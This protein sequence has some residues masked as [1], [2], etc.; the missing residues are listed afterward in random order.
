MNTENIASNLS[1]RI[2][3]YHLP[4]NLKTS[5][6]GELHALNMTIYYGGTGFY[7][8]RIIGVVVQGGG[9]ATTI[10]DCTPTHNHG[11]NEV[12]RSRQNFEA[13]QAVKGQGR[14]R[15]L[16]RNGQRRSMDMVNAGCMVKGQ[17]KIFGAV[18][19]SSMKI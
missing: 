11:Q 19:G 12:K 6:Y 1:Y 5:P 9:G 17:G 3:F 18:K 14:N 8:L 13:G 7:Q 4:N 10:G 16:L 2:E 15:E